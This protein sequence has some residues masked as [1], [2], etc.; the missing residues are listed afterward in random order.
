MSPLASLAIHGRWIAGA[1]GWE[2]AVIAWMASD[3]QA[4]QRVGRATARSGYGNGS[5]GKTVRA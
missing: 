2:E 5:S 4:D 3:G 1:E